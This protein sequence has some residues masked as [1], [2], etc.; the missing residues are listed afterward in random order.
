MRILLIRLVLAAAMALAFASL[1]A[2]R[3]AGAASLRPMVEVASDLVTLGDLFAGAGDLAGRP[4]FRAPAAGVTGALPVADALTA[5]RV[6]G[7]AVDGRPDFAAVTVVRRSRIIDADAFARLV[8]AA[9][10]AR[11]AIAQSDVA[12]DFDGTVPAVDADA[13]AAAPAVLSSLSLQP[14]SGRF[15]A[16]VAVD[17]GAERQTVRLTGRAYETVT[18]PVLARPLDRRDVI[19]AGDLTTARFE[20]RY[21]PARALLDAREI[22]DMAAR[23]PLRAGDILTAGDV[24]PPR[25]VRR[26][27]LVTVVLRRPGLM[28][29]AR[30]RALADGAKGETVAVLNEQSRRTIQGTVLADGL[31]E[32]EGAAAPANLIAQATN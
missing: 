29:S 1:I 15:E 10:A 22:A 3:P 6:A 4:V 2:A 11:L 5:A 32:A 8:A 14:A 20:R 27:E 13:A 25:L 12:V 26:G 17:V 30:G 31:V 28:L 24:E 23:R 21:V 7:L 16:A 19:G 18:L 9:A